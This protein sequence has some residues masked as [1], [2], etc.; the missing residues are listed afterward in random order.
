[1]NYSEREVRKLLNRRKSYHAEKFIPIFVKILKHNLVTSGRLMRIY[2]SNW[3]FNMEKD[4]VSPT[5]YNWLLR[6][7]MYYTLH[8][9][10]GGDIEGVRDHLGILTDAFYELSEKNV[11]RLFD[12]RLTEKVENRDDIFNRAFL[13][14]LKDLNRKAGPEMDNWKWGI[15]NRYRF[16]IKG[17]HKNILK[18]FFV[19]IPLREMDGGYSAF[20][21]IKLFN[22]LTPGIFQGVSGYTSLSL[23]SVE[24]SFTV[25]TD[26]NSKFYYGSDSFYDDYHD[27]QQHDVIEKRILNPPGN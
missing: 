16:P 3:D 6:N 17:A 26:E 24:M 12:N 23:G 20:K 8:D 21:Q 7:Y 19:K 14:T 10:L 13:K 1:V 9:E 2:F 22:G 27:I 4:K 15:V 11:S 5:L 18:N 25:S